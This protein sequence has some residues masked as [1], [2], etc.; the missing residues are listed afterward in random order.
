MLREVRTT[1]HILLWAVQLVPCSTA[2]RLEFSYQ[3]K[4]FIFA[5]EELIRLF[6][7]YSLELIP[8]KRRRRT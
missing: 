2:T 3:Q 8:T 1:F 4:S 7:V 5:S 6:S